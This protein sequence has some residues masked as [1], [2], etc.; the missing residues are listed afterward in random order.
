MGS[1]ARRLMTK[2]HNQPCANTYYS[3][4]LVHSKNGELDKAI[5]NYTKAIALKPDYAEAYYNRGFVYR[6]K[7]D[8]KRAIEDYTKTIEIEPIMPMPIT[9]AAGRGYTSEKRK[10]RNRI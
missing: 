8:Y 2:K 5:K 4:G 7:E 9:V 10:K 3:Q 6:M 1:P